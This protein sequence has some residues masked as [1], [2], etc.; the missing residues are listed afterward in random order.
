[1]R[2]LP[3]KTRLAWTL[4]KRG[5]GVRGKISATRY[6][7]RLAG[8]Y[9]GRHVPVLGRLFNRMSGWEDLRSES[10]SDIDQ[11]TN[12]YRL[13]LLQFKLA[14]IPVRVDP[15]RPYTLN[16]FLPTID[17]LV[18]F[19]GYIAALNLV[20]TLLDEGHRVRLISCEPT[21]TSM[22]ALESAMEKNR[23]LREVLPRCEVH[24]RN[25]RTKAIPFGPEDE[26]LSYS[27]ETTR[28]AHSVAQQ[29]N[30]KKVVFLIQEFEPIFHPL[31]SVHFLAAETYTLPHFALFNS[32]L[33]RDFFK[34][35]KLGVFRDD[36]PDPEG[37][38]AYFSHAIT[39][40]SPPSRE[41]LVNRTTRKVLFY[42]RPESH[43][44]RNLFEIGVMALNA[45]IEAGVF[46]ER[47]TFTGIGS[48]SLSGH[49]ALKHGRKLEMAKRMPLDEY[50]RFVSGHDV[51]LCL[52]YAPHPSVPPF[53]FASAGLPTVTTSF[54]NRPVEAMRSITPNLFAAE[55]TI[56]SI[57]GSMEEAAARADDIDARIAGAHFEK[58]CSWNQSFDHALISRLPFRSPKETPSVSVPARALAA[59]I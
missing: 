4:L 59:R 22:S 10:T 33:L 25:D 34:G 54:A 29:V 20:K 12:I 40:F 30:G 50:Q 19:G 6:I 58:V 41:D 24:L 17:P 14:K 11:P 36:N 42:A 49:L 3:D 2:D 1:M 32:R 46:D 9:I 13:E 39:E 8:R 51:G 53:E 43:A 48:M 52:M 47:W 7:T 57:V 31:D 21:L 15:S 5:R 27:W 56:A 38:H 28:H 23:L 44:G 37:S 55:P 45:A 18:I 16:F 26:F 35:Q